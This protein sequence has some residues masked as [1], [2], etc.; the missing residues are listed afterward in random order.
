MAINEWVSNVFQI[1][2]A[3]SMQLSSGDAAENKALGPGAAAT[4]AE[5]HGGQGPSA[6]GPP[7]KQ[8]QRQGSVKLEEAKVKREAFWVQ[9]YLAAI[10]DRC[11][12]DR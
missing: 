12:E 2:I 5:A 4:A 6:V 1:G 7:A 8:L 3:V 9:A 11:R 10:A